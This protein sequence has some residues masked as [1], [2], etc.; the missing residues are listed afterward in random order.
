[1]RIVFVSL[2][3]DFVG[4]G[5]HS[6]LDLMRHLPKRWQPLLVTPHF[7]PL[8]VRAEQE[9]IDTAHLPMPKLGLASLPALW[10]WLQWLRAERP[11]LLHANNSRAAVYAGVVGRLLGIPMLFHCRIAERDRRLDRL[12]AGLARRIICNSRAVSMRFATTPEKVRVIYNGVS[13]L[14]TTPLEKPWGAESILLFAGRLSEEKQPDVAIQIFQNLANEFPGLH[15]AIAGGDDPLNPG[16]AERLRR[17]STQ[18]PCADRIHWLGRCE[19]MGAWYSVASLLIV[20]SRHEGFGRVIVEAMGCGV[21]VVAFEVGGIPEVLQDGIQGLLVKPND[22]VSMTSGVKR[23]L[24]DQAMRLGMG[25]NGKL[26][27]A[28][29]SLES[30]VVAVARLYEELLNDG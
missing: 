15:L 3:D 17:G 20:P 5:E 22:T 23:L 6:L 19:E 27:A 1:M 10:C 28:L 25:E 18:F 16:Y 21:P 8:A 7:G 29:F 13:G 30:H 4:G 24:R 14:E 12:I 11:G 26:R 2:F 9:G